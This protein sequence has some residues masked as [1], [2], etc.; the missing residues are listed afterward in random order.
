MSI[1]A[2][3]LTDSLYHRRPGWVDGTT[4]FAGMVRKRIRPESRLLDLGAGS[5]KAG[6]V[7]FRG[8]VSRVFGV[9]P[10]PAIER[11]TM[12]DCRVRGL[13]ELLPFRD[14]TFDVVF[15]DWVVEHLP[16]PSGF[17]S[18][19]Y[20]VLK[21]GGFFVFRTGNLRHYVYAIAACTPHWF[22]NLVANRVRRLGPDSEQPHPTYYRI[23]TRRAA[24]R[25]L[26]RVG[27]IEEELL[28]VEAE[29]SYMMFS[30]P[31][32][33]LGVTYERLVNR[34]PFLAEFRACV[35]GCFRKPVGVC[36]ASS[37]QR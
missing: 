10:S 16:D 8:E 4:Q 26:A 32:F 3:Q 34:V 14:G 28:M 21:A 15:C 19:V 24:R 5:G 27:F 1:L 35:F 23:N 6:P 2:E 12:V 20:R 17:A 37:E 33:C 30:L 13:A 36:A 7:N 25:C 31:A 9:D 22:H 11:N 29:P 18:E